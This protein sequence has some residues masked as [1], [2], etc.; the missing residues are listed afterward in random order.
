MLFFCISNQK[1]EEVQENFSKT[2]LNFCPCKCTNLGKRSFQYHQR[3][4]LKTFA[5]NFEQVYFGLSFIYAMTSVLGC[6]VVLQ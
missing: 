2:P 1:I 3:I 6:L 5:N 4:L